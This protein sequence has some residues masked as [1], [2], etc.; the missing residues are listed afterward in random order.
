MSETFDIKPQQIAIIQS[1]ISRFAGSEIPIEHFDFP[2]K[3]WTFKDTEDRFEF[4]INTDERILPFI[5]R[6]TGNFKYSKRTYRLDGEVTDAKAT[7]TTTRSYSGWASNFMEVEKGCWCATIYFNINVTSEKLFY[8]NYLQSVVWY[9]F[10]G[11]IFNE[12]GFKCELCK[13]SKNI[14]LHHLTYERLG[15][16]QPEDVMVLC[17]KCH[18]KAHHV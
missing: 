9:D 14:Q 11:K 5:E 15:N 8:Q 1:E 7:G 4:S 16:E 3:C 18:E 13:S 2:S 6:L 12:R 10:R 17:Q